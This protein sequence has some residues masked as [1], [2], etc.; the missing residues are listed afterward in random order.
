MTL[1]VVFYNWN[2]YTHS[3]MN[4]SIK[5]NIYQVIKRFAIIYNKTQQITL[6][7]KVI[8]NS[9]KRAQPEVNCRLCYK[10]S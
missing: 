6:I 9:S 8:G 5:H 1:L 4:K 10:Y 7:K 3:S 2:Q